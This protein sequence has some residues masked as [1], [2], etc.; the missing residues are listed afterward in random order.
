MLLFL[1]KERLVLKY[2][3]SEVSKI[4]NIP[5]D[6][7]RYL[8]AKDI[9][10]PS[11][12]DNN[13]YRFYEAW[14]I[15]FLIEF[16]KFRS[17]DF[18]VSEVKE[19]LHSDDLNNFIERVDERQEYFEEKLT[20]YML[21]KQKNQ[22]Y[23]NSL[24]N[25]KENIGKFSITNCPDI[26]YFMHRFNYKY[27]A[28]DNFDGLFES[29]LKYFPF[30]ETIVEMQLDA[31]MNRNHN[32]DYEWGFSMRKDYAKAF[33]IPINDKVKH[34]K[35]RESV[36]TVI[37]AGDKGSFSLKLLDGA[38]EFI[39]SNGYELVGD[40]IGNLLARVHEPSGYCRYIE[41]WFPIKKK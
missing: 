41:V 23:I 31:V 18:S 28:K 19:I 35:T 39:E 1:L 37:C 3:I 17:F 6:T 2:K 8:E 40:V 7:L 26:Y 38:L 13:K 25:I 27:E 4:L 22:E 24:N 21:L 14:D 10:N 33:D 11:K 5:V 20:Y 36:Y 16:K 30:V 12:N 29:W 9:V 34:V 32:N 15:N